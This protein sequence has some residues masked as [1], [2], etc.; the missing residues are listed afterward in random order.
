MF[1]AEGEMEVENKRKI[2]SVLHMKPEILAV[3]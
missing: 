3:V 1:L 2:K